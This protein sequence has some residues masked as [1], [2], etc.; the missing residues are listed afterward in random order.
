MLGQRLPARALLS[1]T[2][3]RFGVVLLIAALAGIAGAACALA[4]LVPWFALFAL[5]GLTVPALV[6]DRV[7]PARAVWRG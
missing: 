5:V 3:G 6:I 4:C 2:G 1:P 7:G